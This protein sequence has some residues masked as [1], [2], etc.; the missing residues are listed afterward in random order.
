MRKKPFLVGGDAG[1]KRSDWHFRSYGLAGLEGTRHVKIY[2]DQNKS[3]FPCALA[4]M[5]LPGLFFY[6]MVTTGKGHAPTPESTKDDDCHQD[7]RLGN[8]AVGIGG[9]GIKRF[10]V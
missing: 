3:W 10:E 6:F 9:W 8:D 2:Q 5:S 1:K 4:V 7:D